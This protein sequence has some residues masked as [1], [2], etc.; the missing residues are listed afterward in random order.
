MRLRAQLGRARRRRSRDG[1]TLL[2][3]L[4]VMGVIAVVTLIGMPYFF[5]ILR[6]AKFD[7]GVTQMS[8]LV[9]RAR[10]EAVRRGEPTTVEIDLADS[11]IFAVDADDDLIQIMLLPEGL[12]FGGPAADP[13]AVDGFGA[14][15]KLQFSTTGAADAAGAFRVGDTYENYLEIRIDPPA[16]GQANVLKWVDT[17][18]DWKEEDE[19]GGW[20]WY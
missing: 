2:E 11:S 16:T 9:Q 14:D 6:I 7:N 18:L 15:S 3:M 13:A 19:D 4:V 12:T 10:Y 1:F 20:E 17:D 8:L 5:H